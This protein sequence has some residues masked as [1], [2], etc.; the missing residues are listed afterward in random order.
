MKPG[1]FSI[2]KERSALIVVDMQNDFVRE[3]GALEVPDA[4][5]RIPAVKKLITAFRNIER[6]VIFTRFIAVANSSDWG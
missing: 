4:R 6:P 1:V 5:E 2:K 3:G